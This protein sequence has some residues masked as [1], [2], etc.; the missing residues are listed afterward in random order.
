MA[1]QQN[2]FLEYPRSQTDT[3][4]PFN[5]CFIKENMLNTQKFRAL[6]AKLKAFSGHI[7]PTG[8]ILCMPALGIISNHI[9]SYY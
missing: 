2:Y 3:I 7:W 4:L 6:R 8:R 9:I 5:R 1:D